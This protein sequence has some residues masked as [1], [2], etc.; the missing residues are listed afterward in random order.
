M[1]SRIPNFLNSQIPSRRSHL[2]AIAPQYIKN[3]QLVNLLQTYDVSPPKNKGNIA[4]QFHLFDGV[5]G[6]K[7][8]VTSWMNVIS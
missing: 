2:I 8:Q 7:D 1:P 4:R 3:D 6:L 5:P